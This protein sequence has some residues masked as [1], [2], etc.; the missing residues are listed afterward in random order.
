MELNYSVLQR[1][2]CRNLWATACDRIA[3]PIGIRNEVILMSWIGTFIQ[4]YSQLMDWVVP[5]SLSALLVLNVPDFVR[6]LHIQ[7]LYFF[8]RFEKVFRS[9]LVFFT[10]WPFDFVAF[11]RGKVEGITTVFAISMGIGDL[12]FKQGWFLIFLRRNRRLFP[13]TH[14]I[15][16]LRLDSSVFT[17]SFF[18]FWW[19]KRIQRVNRVFLEA[20]CYWWRRLF[21][22]VFSGAYSSF[23]VW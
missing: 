22:R 17:V 8:E 2:L 6:L 14:T 18:I 12:T 13:Q 4:R 20:F 11:S 1:F 5:P 3:L 15:R 23:T 16:S 9:G 19:D 7:R 21:W 10:C